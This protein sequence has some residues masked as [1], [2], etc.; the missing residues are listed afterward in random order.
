MTSRKTL[1]TAQ[2]KANKLDRQLNETNPGVLGG[3]AM[4][5]G[6]ETEEEKRLCHSQEML[7]SR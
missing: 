5:G 7:I 6:S 1:V 3:T 4:C 2:Q